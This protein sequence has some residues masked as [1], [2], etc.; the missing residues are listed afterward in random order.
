V[1]LVLVII[2][3]GFGLINRVVPQLNVFFFTMPIKGVVAALMLVLLLSYTA[4][5]VAERVGELTHWVDRLV[6]VLAPR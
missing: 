5:L 6:P 4:D 1:I 3:I 2:D